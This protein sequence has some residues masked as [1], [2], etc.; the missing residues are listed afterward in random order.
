[1]SKIKLKKANLKQCGQGFAMEA[2]KHHNDEI[3]KACDSGLMIN[4]IK[5]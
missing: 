3:I 4:I 1:M 5:E 2:L